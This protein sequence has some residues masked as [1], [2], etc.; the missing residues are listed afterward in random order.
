MTAPSP[1]FP[2]DDETLDLLDIA[3]DPARLLVS[4]ETSSVSALLDFLSLS[5]NGATYHPN[6]VIK[7]L[8]DEV[9]RLRAVGSP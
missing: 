5:M 8:S 7:A 9:R 1:A 3:V 6:D 2:I 4:A